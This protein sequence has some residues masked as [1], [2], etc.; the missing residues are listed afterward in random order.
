V[1]ETPHIA[2][3]VHEDAGNVTLSGTFWLFPGR[4]TSPENALSTLR[5]L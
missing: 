5:P 1:R 4:K 2:D 3:L